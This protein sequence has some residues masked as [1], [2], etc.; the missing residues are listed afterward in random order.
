MSYVIV[1]SGVRVLEREMGLKT[2]YKLVLIIYN[3]H[4]YLN[5]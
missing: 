2:I 4:N 3:H 5:N 1:P